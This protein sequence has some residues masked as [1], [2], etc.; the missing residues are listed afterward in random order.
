MDVANQHP[1]ARR[2]L[3]LV[4]LVTTLAV[5]SVSLAVVVPAWSA[6]SAK[7][8]ITTGANGLLTQL[9]YA[10]STAVTRHT[11]VSLC[12][13]TDGESCSGDPFG[14]DAGYLVFQDDNRNRRRDDGETLL[15]R[16]AEAGG[17]VRL[18]T[19]TGRPAVRFAADGHFD[20]FDVPL[21]GGD[22][23]QTLGQAIWQDRADQATRRQMH[24]ADA[25]CACAPSDA[26]RTPGMPA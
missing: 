23:L 3:T 4:E 15:R 16:V 14:W 17:G 12:P 6:L 22:A 25:D 24:D 21:T 18:Q 2:G 11:T 13:S 9:R 8:R 19:S 20:L 10:R 7:T 26:F 5:A 1:R